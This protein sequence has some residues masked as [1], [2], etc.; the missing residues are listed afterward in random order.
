MG[1]LFMTRRLLTWLCVFFSTNT[2]GQSDSVVTDKSS[3]YNNLRLGLGLEKNP[4]IE[5]GFSRLIIEDKGL[6]SGSFCFYVSGQVN[7]ILT[8]SQSD[9]TYG[10]KI[11]FETAWMI[12]M[13]GA[14]VKYLTTGTKSQWF[15]TPRI[16]LSL[17]GSAS[18]LYGI[19]LP[20]KSN[21]IN[22]IGRHQISLTVNVSKRLMKEFK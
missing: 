6:N 13:W 8:E 9:Y 21:K 3:L 2:F 18:L 19:N 10:G 14:E 7:K 4:F 12:G 16:G 11:G 5:V 22:E 17:L 20:T 1:N 15:F